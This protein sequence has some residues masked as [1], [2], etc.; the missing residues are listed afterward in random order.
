[1]MFPDMTWETLANTLQA[2]NY[3]LERAVTSILSSKEGTYYLIKSFELSLFKINYWF[4]DK[5]CFSHLLAETGQ[6]DDDIPLSASLNVSRELTVKE[7]RDHMVDKYAPEQT[8]RASHDTNILR[9]MFRY[10][11]SRQFNL[12]ARPNVVFDGEDGMDADGLTRE[13]C[14]MMMSRM[15]DGDGGIVLFE[16]QIDH[17]IPVHNEQYLASQYY[18]YAGQLI[19]YCFV[20]GGF[21][22]TGLSRAIAEYLKSGE[23]N[24]CLPYL[25]EEDIPDLDIREK[26]K[27]VHVHIHLTYLC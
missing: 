26:L 12:R 17:L 10:L 1:M 8:I 14:H 24:E 25:S 20:H 18:K 23:V 13:L 5:Q 4:F 21:G 7:F 22:I 11:K 16:G 6:C 2:W 15:R 3:D 27:E 9:D 19:A